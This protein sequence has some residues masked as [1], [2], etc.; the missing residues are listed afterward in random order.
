[1][2]EVVKFPINTPVEVT[3]QFEAGKRVEGRYGDQVMYSL[4]DNRVMYVPPYVEQRFQELA[5]GAGEPLLLCKRQIKDGN[6][7][8]TEWSVRR[9][10]QQP[11]ALA[12]GTADSVPPDTPPGRL[13]ATPG[14]HQTTG[15]GAAKHEEQPSAN[16]TA[17]MAQESA[18]TNAQH[19]PQE[20]Q[21]SLSLGGRG[22]S[23]REPRLRAS[24]EARSAPHRV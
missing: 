8:R 16:S 15:N 1:M 17:P 14:E 6:R 18:T 4:L 20:S 7:N 22:A 3:L 13:E 19:Q 21:V 23:P 12:E 2:N 24:A 10:P 9:A 11:L 5:I